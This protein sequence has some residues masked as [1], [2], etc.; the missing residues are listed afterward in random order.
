MADYRLTRRAEGDLAGIA[1]YTIERFGIEQARRYR[2]GLESC[3]RMLADGP[4]IGRPAE[5]L[6]PGLRRYEVQAHI[7][8]YRIEGDGI[9]IVRVLH[10][11]MDAAG[12]F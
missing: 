9:L 6:S 2:E 5:G 7:V 11:K 8:F 3:F 10:E 12:R 4:L 1:D